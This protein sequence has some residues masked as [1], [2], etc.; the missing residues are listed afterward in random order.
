LIEMAGV[1][2][3]PSSSQTTSSPIAETGAAHNEG[4][5]VLVGD[6]GVGWAALMCELGR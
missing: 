1:Q 5:A 3:P 6:S 4:R 2:Y